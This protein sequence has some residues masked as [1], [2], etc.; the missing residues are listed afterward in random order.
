[1]I[2]RGDFIARVR[3]LADEKKTTVK[4]ALDILEL[5]LPVFL[6]ACELSQEQPKLSEEF[7]ELQELY[8]KTMQ[9]ML[10]HQKEFQMEERQAKLAEGKVLLERSISTATE[11]REKISAGLAKESENGQLAQFTQAENDVELI[12]GA[13][14]QELDAWLVS[15]RSDISSI[16]CSKL[17]FSKSIE[18]QKKREEKLRQLEMEA[19]I[20]ER[21]ALATAAV[22]FKVQIHMSG[23]NIKEY[24][25]QGQSIR[26]DIERAAKKGQSLAVSKKK[27]ELEEYKAEIAKEGEA[28]EEN[29]DKLK[30]MLERLK[31]VDERLHSFGVSIPEVDTLLAQRLSDMQLELSG[32]MS[33]MSM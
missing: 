29:E 2:P 32:P 14:M 20:R 28:I 17:L 22:E 24:E 7:N 15:C 21:T 1:M 10:E 9:E 4:R 18:T 26:K 12:I 31:V 8:Q 6:R 13:E 33:L 19:L 5:A 30:K 27:Q 16:E 11:E 23:E 25:E 3:L